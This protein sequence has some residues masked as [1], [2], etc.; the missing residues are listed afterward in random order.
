[1]NR[2]VVSIGRL[3]ASEALGRPSAARAHALL[4]VERGAAKSTDLTNDFPARGRRY[5]RV[6]SIRI[7]RT[8]VSRPR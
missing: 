2:I 7:I 4:Y 5:T 1:M 8:A 3:K 6:V